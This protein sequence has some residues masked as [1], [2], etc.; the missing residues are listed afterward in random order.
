MHIGASRLMAYIYI[1]VLLSTAVT[2][3]TGAAL[4]ADQSSHMMR[5]DAPLKARA[6]QNLAVQLGSMGEIQLTSQQ[7]KME[8]Q[9]RSGEHDG[10]CDTV[11]TLGV[12]GQDDCGNFTLIQDEDL[13][14]K[15][16][17]EMNLIK[18]VMTGT[19][20]QHT[21]LEK[22]RPRG[23]F[24]APCADTAGEC[25]YLNMRD[26]DVNQTVTGT[27]TGTPVCVKARFATGNAS[28]NASV[29]CPE[30][31]T[32]IENESECDVAAS[33]KLHCTGDPNMIKGLPA[34]EDGVQIPGSAVA[35]YNKYP[36]GCFVSESQECPGEPGSTLSLA[37]KTVFFN[38]VKVGISLPTNPTGS[39]ICIATKEGFQHAH[40]TAK[41][42]DNDTPVIWFCVANIGSGQ[43]PFVVQGPFSN[44]TAAKTALNANPGSNTSRQMICEMSENGPKS[45]PHK[46]G[47]EDQDAGAGGGFERWWAGWPDMNLMNQ[48][49]GSDTAC[50]SGS[51]M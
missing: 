15:A 29:A 42:T 2:T 12:D 48:K 34:Y 51:P 44:I 21:D 33:C 1:F 20:S 19:I 49:C 9:P 4:T 27:L 32:E 50:L 22:Q 5:R 7:Q 13:C 31:Y 28:D 26:I 10:L 47:G 40:S 25:I 46:V 18:P 6:H 45:D 8:E 24:K 11:F 23:C 36:T 37:G 41:E 17:D 16:A 14:N 43:G 35:D 30:G 3:A 38:P 39:P